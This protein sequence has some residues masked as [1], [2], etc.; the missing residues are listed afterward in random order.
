[1]AVSLMLDRIIFNRIGRE[2][3]QRN[4]TQNFYSSLN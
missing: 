4:N 1:M 2:V 3:D